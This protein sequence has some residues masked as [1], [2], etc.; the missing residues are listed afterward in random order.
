MYSFPAAVAVAGPL[1]SASNSVTVVEI[2][3]GHINGAVE[4]AVDIF[5]HLLFRFVT[6]YSSTCQVSGYVS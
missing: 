1:A 6:V 3:I 5:Y 2:V 4:F